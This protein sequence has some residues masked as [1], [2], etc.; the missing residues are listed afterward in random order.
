LLPFVTQA[1]AKA[2]IENLPVLLFLGVTITSVGSI[3][4]FTGL[5]HVKAQNASILSLLEPVSTIFFAYI[6]L[7]DPISA[8]TLIG[9]IFILSSSFLVSLEEE[10]KTENEL[11]PKEKI[12]GVTQTFSKKV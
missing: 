7:K 3:L 11:I 9:C 8:K 2:L 5:E 1:P 10:N 4:Y 6:L 12:S